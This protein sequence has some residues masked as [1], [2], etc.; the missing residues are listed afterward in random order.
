MESNF[1]ICVSV[2]FTNSPC[3]EQCN[4]MYI[5]YC[6]NTEIKS[7]SLDTSFKN[8]WY[9]GLDFLVVFIFFK[10]KAPIVSGHVLKQTLYTLYCVQSYR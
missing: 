6:I 10:C 1:Q 9:M 2:S 8:I 7:I 5:L 3:Q 4:L